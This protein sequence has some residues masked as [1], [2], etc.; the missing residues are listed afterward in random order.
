[1]NQNSKGLW[2]GLIVVIVIALLGWWWYSMSQSATSDMASTTAATTTSTTA[3]AGV[4]VNDESSSNVAT[5]AQNIT[6][7][8]TFGSWF[9]STG[10]AAQVTGAGPYTIFVP[11]DAA[12]GTL[13]P[14]TFSGLSAAGRKRFIE[15]YVVSGRAIDVSAQ[16]TGSIQ[17]LSGDALNFSNANNIPMVDSA[18]I[19]TEYK[20][21]NGV[22]YV[23]NAGLIPP[24]T[25]TQ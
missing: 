3:S 7:A 25:A 21:S 22:V 12:V 2:I 5:I 18:I 23:I 16:T 11:S 14:G 15:Y 8:S 1:M 17:A 9:A 4:P 6:G 24:Q 10:V 20:G 13:A 19:T